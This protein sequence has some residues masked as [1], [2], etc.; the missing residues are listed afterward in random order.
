M[1]SHRREAKLNTVDAV[2][3]VYRYFS[4]TWWRVGK[5]IIDNSRRINYE[6]IISPIML[7]KVKKCFGMIKSDGLKVILTFNFYRLVFVFTTAFLFSH[8][9]IIAS[10]F[11]L[12]GMPQCPGNQF[13]HAI[14]H[15]NSSSRGSH[16]V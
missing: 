3:D 6:G 14:V 8:A 13:T 11:L 10:I 16:E 12:V 4:Y 1:S 7:W 9:A 2:A 5:R 15:V